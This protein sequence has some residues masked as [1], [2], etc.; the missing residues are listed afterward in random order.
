MNPD[1]N[2]SEFTLKC[3]T[4]PKACKIV[5]EDRKTKALKSSFIIFYNSISFLKYV[6]GITAIFL[7]GDKYIQFPDPD[8]SLFSRL[9][10]FIEAKYD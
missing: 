8:Y 7:D 1:E 10:T 6:D 9:D 4:Y 3:Y 5:M 2:L